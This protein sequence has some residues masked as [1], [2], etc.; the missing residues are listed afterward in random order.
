MNIYKFFLALFSRN[1]CVY[2]ILCLLEPSRTKRSIPFL[3]KLR[4]FFY[5]FYG[6]LRVRSRIPD[7]NLIIKYLIYIYI[8]IY[9]IVIV[10][11]IEMYSNT[12]TITTVVFKLL[13]LTPVD[14]PFTHPPPIFFFDDD[15]FHT[16]YP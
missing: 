1:P 3:Y 7:Y 14:P 4:E 6:F 10:I 5:F 15:I 16:V 9:T 12:M 13:N 8:Q 2:V 11:F